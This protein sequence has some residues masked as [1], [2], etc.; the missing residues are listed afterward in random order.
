MI[1]FLL[2]ILRR[3]QR[4]S[5]IKLCCVHY[6]QPITPPCQRIYDLHYSRFLIRGVQFDLFVSKQAS[7]QENTW[8]SFKT[9]LD[10]QSP[11]EVVFFG[12]R[13]TMWLAEWD[14]WDYP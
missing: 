6:V 12:C 9:P 5:N 2:L 10:I 4:S 7:F 11:G 13:A 8:Q 3:F 1:Q 14:V